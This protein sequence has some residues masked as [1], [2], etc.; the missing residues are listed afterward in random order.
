MFN[1]RGRGG[2]GR[3]ARF[4]FLWGKT[5]G[6]SIPLARIRLLSYEKILMQ[7]SNL[8]HRPDGPDGPVGR[9]GREGR[10]GEDRVQVK[11]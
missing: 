1:R 3:R 10:D 8:N 9:E 7:K 2:I 5:R 4:R 6:G 11:L